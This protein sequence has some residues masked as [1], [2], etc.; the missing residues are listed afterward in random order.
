MLPERESSRPGGIGL[1]RTRGDAPF[2]REEEWLR[3]VVTPH[4]R[5]CSCAG[6]RPRGR[7]AGYPAHAG[8]LPTSTSCI[9][10]GP[11]LPRTRGDAPF[12]PGAQDWEISGLP[13]TR[14]DAPQRYSTEIHAD[15]VTPHTRGCSSVPARTFS[16]HSGY[17]AHAGMLPDMPTPSHPDEGLP[18]T[19]GDA[20]HDG[21]V[22]KV[23]LRVTPHTRG[24]SRVAERPRADGP[25]Y[26]A[27]AGMLLRAVCLARAFSRLPRTRGDAPLLHARDFPG[28]EVTPHTRGCFLRVLQWTWTKSRRTHGEG[29]A[30]IDS[31]LF[32]FFGPNRTDLHSDVRLTVGMCLK[33]VSF[34]VL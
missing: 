24:C 5:G 30:L 22:G 3:R 15:R 12:K 23:G 26:P 34:G 25:G 13:R 28:L 17:P 18:R 8:M 9:V 1:P 19:R 6:I 10:H 33:D 2:L 11:G 14:G 7:S 31:T 29:V 20:P 21:L 27:H 32:P 4:T 16:K